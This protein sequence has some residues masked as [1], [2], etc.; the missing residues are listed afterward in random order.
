MHTGVVEG[1]MGLAGTAGHRLASTGGGG[2]EIVAFY[3]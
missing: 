1:S 3:V 2:G